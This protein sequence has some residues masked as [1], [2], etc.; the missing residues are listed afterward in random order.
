MNTIIYLQSAYCECNDAE[1]H[2]VFR[3]AR[4]AK[5]SVRVIPYAE[6]AASRLQERRGK[7]GVPSLC[8]LIDFWRP[9]GAIVDC[10]AAVGLLEPSDFGALPVVF[11]DCSTPIGGV[12]VRSDGGK[13]G[14]SAVQELLSLGFRNYAFVPWI[15][16][17]GWSR[18][19]GDV[20]VGGIRANGLP[21]HCFSWN[22]ESTE[23]EM[24]R[25]LTDWLGKLPRPVGVFAA[26]DYIASLV[27]SCAGSL[28]LHLPD[29]MAV[30]GVDNDIRI[31]E[32][33]HPTIS[34]VSPDFEGAG[35]MAAQLLDGMIRHPGTRPKDAFFGV[36]RIVRRESTRLLVRKDRR[37][38][39]VLDFIHKS[40]HEGITPT[41]VAARMG[42]SRRLLEMRF[43]EMTGHTMLDE[44]RAVRMERAKR[45]L[46]QSDVSIED[47]ARLCGYEDSGTFRRAFTQEVG[48]SPSFYRKHGEKR[49]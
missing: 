29:D 40:A 7:A 10:G 17:L 39:T 16:P 15:R 11:L 4:R 19:R 38:E 33:S 5:W 13:I 41:A 21:C 27:V 32:L 34:S 9:A 28:R 2:G 49:P 14:E 30:L 42:C 46:A 22:G 44:I 25:S 47:V 23:V 6:A 35:Y 26:N 24:L 31:C 37:I 8:K 3:W 36:D 1:I 12:A 48:A 43:R 20:F 45:M 18:E